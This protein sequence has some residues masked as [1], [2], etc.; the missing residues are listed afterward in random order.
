M[1]REGQ[2]H[3]GREILGNVSQHEKHDV[4]ETHS[5]VINL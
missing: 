2:K 1:G 4:S 3:K 5:I